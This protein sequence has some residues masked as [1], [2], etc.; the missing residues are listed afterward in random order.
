MESIRKSIN[1]VQEFSLPLIGGVFVALLAANLFHHEYHDILHWAPVHGIMVFGHEL[2]FHFVVNDIFMVFFFGIAAKEITESCLP[3]GDLNPIGKAINP[4]IATLGGVFGPVGVFFAGLFLCFQ[5][6]V[7]DANAVEWGTVA[8]GWGI[9]TAT[10]IALAWLVARAVFGK[11][12]PAVNFLL[13]LAVADDAI[14]LGIIAV[15]YGDPANPAKPVYLLLVLAA[16]GVAFGLRKM[17]VQSWPV[18]IATAGPLAW[19]G[20]MLAHLH[21]ALALV[22]IVPF[23]PGPK[24]D[25]GLFVHEDTVEGDAHHDDYHS[26]LHLFEHQLK[27]FVDF[28]LF[29]FAFA[30]AGVELSGIGAMSWLILGALVVGKTIGIGLMGVLAEALGFRLPQGMSRGDLV[31]A[32][33]IAALGLTVALFVAS[34]AFTDPALQGEAKMGALFSGFV[35]LA[36]ILLG[37]ALGFGKAANAEAGNEDEELRQVA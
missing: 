13:L 33:F 36:A 19:S 28:G 15:F 16:M 27:P 10:D 30:N 22:P 1:F 25:T 7:Y 4:L 31:M 12:H 11:A 34:A 29:F 21:P 26:P 3:G 17:K 2:N 32:G 5:L 37:K 24:R 14:G 20:L 6:G 23:I 8:N 18:Y 9:P 35:G